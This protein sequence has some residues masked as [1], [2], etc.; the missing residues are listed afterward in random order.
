[1]VQ[2]RRLRS[3]RRRII[4]KWNFKKWEGV[5]VGFIWL[6]IDTGGELL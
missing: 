5:R 4:L 1:M 2:V 6:R 3:A